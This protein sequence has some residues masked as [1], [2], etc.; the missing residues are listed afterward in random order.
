MIR[1]LALFLVG[2]CLIAAERSQPVDVAWAAQDRL[3]VA[4]ADVRGLREVAL[5]PRIPAVVWPLPSAPRAVA[6]AGTTWA[7]AL[8]DSD[9]VALRTGSGP[10][11]VVATPAMPVAVAAL[12]GGR[13]AVAC[14]QAGVVAIVDPGT[15]AVVA[16]MPAGRQ[17]VSVATVGDALIVGN[18]IPDTAA[19]DPAHAATVHAGPLAGPLVRIHLPVGSTGVRG[20]AA[21]PGTSLAV[22]VH[23]VGHTG[24]VVTHTD[25]GWMAHAAATL[26]DV[27]TGQIETSIPLDLPDHGAADPWGV[28]VADGRAWITAVGGQRLVSVDL[29][30]RPGPDTPLSDGARRGAVRHRPLLA[31]LPGPRGIA[32]GSDGRIA[33]AAAYAGAVGILDPEGGSTTRIVLGDPALGDPERMGAFLFHDAATGFQGWLSC[34]TCHPDSRSDGLTWD[35]LNDGVGNPKN[36][37][38]MW[39][40]ADRAP[41]MALGV[42]A[43]PPTAVRAGFR[44][45]RFH[46]P[47]ETQVDAVLAYVRA[48]Q[49]RPGHASGPA[50]ARGQAIFAGKAVAPTAMRDPSARS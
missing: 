48:L 3:L 8:P 17:P 18:L 23:M 27:R 45:V 6:V 31:D 19:T 13:W 9:A 10:W 38:T 47:H 11:R 21:I 28:V 33:I 34:A 26:V 14:Q 37:R 16:Q 25:R 36:V 1:G 49:P 44:F 41:M 46:E 5:D 22:V 40:A 42:R 24:M 12:P 32:R 15:D 7:V 35:L 30:Y 43:D 50:V 2:T 4:D 20:V 29:S 39:G